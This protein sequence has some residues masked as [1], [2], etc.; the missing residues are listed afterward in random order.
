MFAFSLKQSALRCAGMVSVVLGLA[1]T[2]AA[3]LAAQAGQPVAFVYVSYGPDGAYQNKVT[4]YAAD[5]DG[6]LTV[7][8]GSP[9]N[10]NVDSMV[11]TNSYL[12]GSETLGTFVAAFKI[13]PSGALKWT[14]STDVQQF[15]TSAC[16]NPGELVLD[17][18]G[19]TLYRAQLVGGLCDSTEYLSL[20]IDKTNGRLKFIGRSAQKFLWND[21]LSFN[22]TNHFAYGS[23]C[24]DYQGNY[25]DT[26]A[27]LVR[28]SDGFMDYANVSTP[29]PATQNA[30]DFYCRALTAADP[31]GHLAVAMTPINPNLAQ[32]DGPTQI[33]SYLIH[34]DG[35]LTTR[36]TWKNMPAT[37]AGY[38]FD[39]S[40]SPS[41]K[42]LAVG[43]TSG[44]EVF[45]FNGSSPVTHYTGL[46][47][48]DQVNQI[49]WDHNNHLYALGITGKL[50]VFTVTSTG[51]V[52]APGSPYTIANAR[53][54]A[55]RTIGSE[56]GQDQQ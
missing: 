25:L 4:G 14:Y 13:Q 26:F 31:V 37:L 52:E 53:N 19:A 23:A 7:L 34:G 50:H 20:Q 21:P 48:G 33:G 1:A 22:S 41:G 12:F 40:M 9:F 49:F 18:T 38:V 47:T 51:A 3:V 42:L 2:P 54:I 15:D 11:T 5:A 16:A 39:I 30:S 17:H 27:A 36:S 10:A 45:H 43:G 46:L 29:A 6:R 28:H 24:V 55:V 8:P 32:A 44:L 35:S 56:A